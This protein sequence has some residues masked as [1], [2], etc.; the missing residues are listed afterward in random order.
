MGFAAQCP[1]G[2][3]QPLTLGGERV[4]VVTSVVDRPEGAIGLGY[5]R[6][7]AGGAGLVVKADQATVQ[8]VDCPFLS[9]GYLTP[10]QQDGS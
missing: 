10:V 5:V 1:G 6:T 3:R 2:L 9:R 7:K 8:L 4:G